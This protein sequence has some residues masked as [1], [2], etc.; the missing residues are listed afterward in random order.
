[1]IITQDQFINICENQKFTWARVMQPNRELFS[2][3]NFDDSP[4]FIN[5]INK[6]AAMYPGRWHIACKK[7]ATHND[8][9]LCKFDVI[10]GDVKDESKL[11]GT[12]N[13][14][15]YGQIDEDKIAE[16][17]RKELKAEQ[18][19]KEKDE[20]IKELEKKLEGQNSTGEKFATLVDLFLQ[21]WNNKPTPSPKLAGTE[22]IQQT[23]Q[24]TEEEK[25]MWTEGLKLFVKH[26][27][28][29]TFLEIAQKVDSSPSLINTVKSFLN[30]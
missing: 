14:P 9:T 8:H 22:N 3:W 27:D 21:R 25:A 5:E 20:K 19:Q 11:Q 7:L 28:A 30:V 29:Q 16:R 12:S 23:P 26:T 2:M 4:Q 17:I 1:M 6:F 13:Y 15:Q 24:A 10:L 18:D